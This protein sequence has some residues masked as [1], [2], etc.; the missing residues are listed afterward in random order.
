M[1]NIHIPYELIAR[2]FA[3]ECNEDERRQVQEWSRLHPDLMAEISDIWQQ[4][5]S[6]EFTPDVE[7]ALQHVNDRIEVKKKSFSKRL[8]IWVGS[9]AAVILLLVCIIGI[10]H[11]STSDNTFPDT[12]LTLNTNAKETLEYTL[13]DGSKV[14][15]NQSSALCYPEVFAEDLREVY[16]EGEAF[17]DV[18]PDAEKPFV[19]HANNTLTRV[20]GT[21]FGLR[22][23]KDGD[24]VIVTV[25]TGI[26]CF[27]TEESSES[28]ELRQGEQGIYEP[29]Q[30]RLEKNTDS[31]PNL[32]AW[33]TRTLVF[34]QT[35][36][37]EVAAVIEDVYHTP[38][39]VDD[40]VAGLQLTSTFDQLSLEEIMQIIEMTLRVRSQLDKNGV[41]LTGVSG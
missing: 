7:Q 8:F 9:A 5:P 27:S 36:L 17:F 31:D 12:L 28:I 21:S 23:V 26:I 11:W 6:D 29:K 37:S 35:P 2:Y 33:K 25:S 10:R 1:N 18:S 3:G 16:L 38:V 4:I 13:P 39:S 40:S 41:L 22:A 19:I 15:L 24:E 32:L 30:R 20:V 14:W 34:R